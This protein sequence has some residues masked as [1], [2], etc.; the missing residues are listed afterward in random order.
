[1]LG[2]ESLYVPED[3]VHDDAID[4][5]GE[6]RPEARAAL[7]AVLRHDPGRLMRDVHDG[8]EHAGIGFAAVDGGSGFHVDPVPRVIGADEWAELEAGLAQ[9][10]RAL[11]AF[12]ADAYGDRAIV[13]AGVVPER[14]LDDA[15]FYEPAATELHP[16]G[17]LWI[18]VAGLDLVR[19]ADGRFLV[20][21]DNVRTPSGI[22]YA[23]GTRAQL[24]ARLEIA[25]QDA[26]R[27]LDEAIGLL[28]ATLRAAAP[29]A[30]GGEPRLAVLTD[31]AENSA[32]WEHRFLASGLGLGIH[33]PEEMEVRDGRLH[34]RDGGPRIDV[35][36]R[37]TDDSRLDSPVGQLLREPLAAGTLGCL[38]VPA[39]GVADD[40][41]AH[42]YVEDMVRFYLSQE[43]LLPSVRTFD[44]QVDEVLAEALDRMDELVVKPR[45]GYGGVGVV[46]GP[47]AD[48]HDVER[49]REEVAADPAGYVAQELIMLSTHP[50]VVEGRLAPRHVD[51]RPF[52][53][54]Q[55]GGDV[56]VMPGGLTRVALDAGALVVNSSQNGGNKDTW[57][58]A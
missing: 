3:G 5:A 28:G 22:G 11:N 37:R 9:R 14:V 10:V 25:P 46:I 6:A 54:L 56:H 58:M 18:G 47:H 49:T 44:L 48:T 8:C 15:E 4:A 29:G 57:V 21:E 52:A 39:T 16:P 1:M 34:I 26:P 23:I 40:K 43:P 55:P 41:L 51:L 2:P 42:A 17:D 31:G 32:I 27:P 38:N 24:A 30:A 53:F 45:G 36:Y 35:V 19:G 33:T 20:L 50:T 13:A 7:E 12:V